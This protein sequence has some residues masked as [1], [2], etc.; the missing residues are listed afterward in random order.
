MSGLTGGG[1]DAG[2]EGA[3]GAVTGVMESEGGSSADGGGGGGGGSS[4][5]GAGSSSG[6]SGGSLPGEDAGGPGDSSAPPDGS[7]APN[8]DA[9]DSPDIGTGTTDAGSG[10][11]PDASKPPAFCASLSPAPLFCDDFDEGTALATPWDQLPN[12]NGSEQASTASVVSA[13]DAMRV[14]VVPNASVAAIDVAGYKSLTAK[15]GAA[16]TVTASFEIRI[17]AGD[18][19]SN[20]DA[21]LGAIQLWNGSTYWD[22]ELEVFYVAATNDFKVSMSEDGNTSSYVQHFVTPHIPLATWTLV[23][24]AVTLPAGSGGAAPAT[25]AFNGANVASTTVHVSTS[26]PIPE[27]LVG[28]TYATPCASG[29]SLAYDNVTF[30]DR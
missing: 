4:S 6:S 15:Q 14:T 26:D 9:G 11:E 13:P 2:P 30:D 12:T 5:G 29:W 3:T 10:G 24:L 27:I 21:I 23:T 16:G 28:T 20:S 8:L 19:S 22:L 18:E 25:M 7:P 1:G 17:D